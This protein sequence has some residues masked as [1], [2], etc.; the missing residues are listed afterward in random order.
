MTVT[1]LVLVIMIMRGH[2]DGNFVLAV[3]LVYLAFFASCVGPVFWT[4]IPESFPND[5]RGTAMIV[6]VLIQW[7]A[8]AVVVLFF[9]F[10]FHVIGRASTFSFLAAMAL[11]Q[12]LFALFYIPET[13]NKR[14]EEIEV[15]WT[16]GNGSHTL[17][18][19]SERRVERRSKLLGDGRVGGEKE[20]TVIRAGGDAQFR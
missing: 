10:A 3:I 14:L 19:S 17:E 20:E 5:V 7:V 18:P 12:G 15:Y 1:L 11:A 2:F 4:L 6:P 16:S 13:K 8:N 9:P